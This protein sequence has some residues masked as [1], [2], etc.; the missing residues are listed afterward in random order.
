MQ[1]I[2]TVK[3]SLVFRELRHIRD[4][5]RTP[6]AWCDHTGDSATRASLDAGRVATRAVR[7]PAR[8]ARPAVVRCRADAHRGRRVSVLL[9][10]ER[11]PHCAGVPQS[12]A[13]RTVRRAEGQGGMAVAV[14]APQPA[15]L[16]DEGALGLRGVPHAVELRDPGDTTHDSARYL[17]LVLDHTA[18]AARAGLGME[19]RPVGGARRRP[20]AGR[21]AGSHPACA[22]N[23]GETGSFAVC[24]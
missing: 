24:R 11:I 4:T 22:R 8:A 6:C 14:A 20:R 13:R 3:T 15:G 19:A 10:F 18:L 12:S 16:V 17:G 23:P 21:E 7:L 5:W 1:E 2:G 9:A